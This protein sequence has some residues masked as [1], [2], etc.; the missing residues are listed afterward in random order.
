MKSFLTLL[1]LLAAGISSAAD[2]VEH[3]SASEAYTD[4]ETKI[5]FP[6]A[7]GKFRKKE[8]SRSFN[9]MIGTTIRYTDP[10]GYCADVYL[11]SLPVEKKE[12]S[13]Q[14][15]QKHFQEVKNAVLNLVSKGLALKKVTLTGE[16]MENRNGIPVYSAEFLLSW[17]DGITQRSFLKL[18]FFRGKIIK[19]RISSDPEH[20]E[21]FSNEILKIF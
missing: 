18:F 6:A 5:A 15:I 10:D 7:A 11:Y 17:S 21:T 14:L 19:F 16:K 13:Q 9:P 3:R 8:V 1:I 4:P 2:P 12:L 20:A